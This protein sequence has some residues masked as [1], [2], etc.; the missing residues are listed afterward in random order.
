MCKLKLIAE[1]KL[2][3]PLP[4]ELR[5]CRSCTWSLPY[6]SWWI[7]CWCRR[8]L[9]GLQSRANNQLSPPHIH[10]Y[11]L[12]HACPPDSSLDIMCQCDDCCYLFDM[13]FG[14]WLCRVGGSAMRWA[15]TITPTPQAE[16][17][18]T[19]PTS[20]EYPGT[21]GGHGWLCRLRNQG[22]ANILV[23]TDFFSDKWHFCIFGI[24]DFQIS[25]CGKQ[26][27]SLHAQHPG[28]I[29]GHLEVIDHCV[30][31]Q[32]R[33]QSPGRTRNSRPQ[34]VQSMISLQICHHHC[35]CYMPWCAQNKIAT[36]LERTCA[37]D[38]ISFKYVEMSTFRQYGC[39][40]WHNLQKG[41][42]LELEMPSIP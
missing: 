20:R 30:G 34:T 37:P 38:L 40:F 32:V 35:Q 1:W 6:R 28:N 13:F 39:T 41:E 2:L 10:G 25:R 12:D 26:R 42:L 14:F 18:R 21:Y 15:K 19:C 23:R 8:R 16:E 3:V 5:W 4:P 27:K 33:H 22:L 7:H 36:L 9:P 31:A 24:P 29:L 11:P 17:M